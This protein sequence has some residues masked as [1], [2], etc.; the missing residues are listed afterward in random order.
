MSDLINFGEAKYSG[1]ISPHG[2][3]IN[4]SKRFID[5]EKHL[6]DYFYLKNL[7]PNSAVENLNNDNFGVVASFSINSEDP[8]VVLKN[9]IESA[10]EK[11]SLDRIK[12]VYLVGV[13]NGPN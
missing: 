10:Q 5:D 1:N 7:V 4:Q 3:A 6:R 12:S 2:N 13:S 8:L 11:L 9:S